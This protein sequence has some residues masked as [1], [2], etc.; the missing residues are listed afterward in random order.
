MEK[1]DILE[2]QH[3]G[4]GSGITLEIPV[5]AQKAE[6]FLSTGIRSL[7]FGGLIPAIHTTWFLGSFWKGRN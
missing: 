7:E 3:F 5:N 6:F 4:D 2:I 1:W